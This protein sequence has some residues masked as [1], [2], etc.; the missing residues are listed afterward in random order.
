MIDPGE[1]F[2]SNEKPVLKIDEFKEI[3]EH[4]GAE[5]TESILYNKELEE[6]IELQLF[7][8][9]L[10]LIAYYIIDEEKYQKLFK[11]SEEVL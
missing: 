10:R 9:V 7:T 5:I 3:F 8:K 1:D 11:K 2:S 4:V 6:G